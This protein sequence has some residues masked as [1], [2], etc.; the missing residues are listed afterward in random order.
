LESQKV[1]EMKHTT[2]LDMLL[3]WLPR[4]FVCWLE[5]ICLMELEKKQQVAANGSCVSL[6]A[7]HHTASTNA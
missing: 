3:G 5:D 2:N 7:Q 4:C 1:P 6:L